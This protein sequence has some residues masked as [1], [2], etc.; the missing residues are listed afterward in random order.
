M[1]KHKPKWS[2]NKAA[3]DATFH[4]FAHLYHGPMIEAKDM[5]IEKL[6]DLADRYNADIKLHSHEPSLTKAH[7]YYSIFS[8][9]YLSYLSTSRATHTMNDRLYE[10]NEVYK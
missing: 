5:S 2:D 4:H 6:L 7:P 8:R 9:E 10:P 1:P 3:T